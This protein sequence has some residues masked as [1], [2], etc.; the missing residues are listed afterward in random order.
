VQ[1]PRSIES[2]FRPR[3][4]FR[5]V[6]AALALFA[7]A[8]CSNQN[9]SSEAQKHPTTTTTPSTLPPNSSCQVAEKTL[10]PPGTPNKS[11]ALLVAPDAGGRIGHA[12][13][14]FGQTTEIER[15]S[16]VNDTFN[17]SQPLS[18]E[19]VAT[20]DFSATV[21]DAPSVVTFDI[22]IDNSSEAIEAKVITCPEARTL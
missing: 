14:Y 12:I 5:T 17:L 16:F 1:Y 19:T 20:H 21:D 7:G 6:V 18:E 13:L 10:Y 4:S 22:R 8:S 9:H 2:S 11:D 3:R 15:L